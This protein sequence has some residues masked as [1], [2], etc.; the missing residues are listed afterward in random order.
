MFVTTKN[1]FEQRFGY[2]RAVR[3]G[4]FIFVSGT[5]AL[6]PETGGIKCPGD[7][8]GQA[9]AAFNT[10]L[11]AIK[12]LGGKAADVCRIRMF[13]GVSETLP[14]RTTQTLSFWFGGVERALLAQE[15]E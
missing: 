7:A 13:V 3:K 14:L 6:D 4:P 1:I 2:H 15:L 11:E 10:G 8:Y 12:Q 9:H 5:T